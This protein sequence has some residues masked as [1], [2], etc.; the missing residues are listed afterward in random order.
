MDKPT[1]EGEM[2]HLRPIRADDAAAMW[3]MVS[4][5]DSRR[6]TGTTRVFTRAEV[7]AWCASVSRIEGR[8]DL[9]ITAN[10]SDEYLGE[11][12][13][14]E[15]DEVVGSAGLRLVMRPAYRGRGYGT[16]AIELV[17]GLAFDGIGLHRVGIDVLSI[18]ARAHSL[19]E[20]IGFRVEGRRRDAYRDGDG[21]CD[22]ILMGMLDDEYR[23]LRAA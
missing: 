7:D 19:Y 4:D 22:G 11:I 9:A 14:N 20:N 16:E 1:L 21:W 13:L 10:G 23:A 12:V 5:P 6:T 3:D 8:I 2:I 15:I 18:N 17:L